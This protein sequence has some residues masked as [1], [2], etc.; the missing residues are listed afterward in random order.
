MEIKR[1]MEL[2]KAKYTRRWRG[3]D[4][5]W[6][7]EY[8]QPSAP[9][10]RA[11]N[12]VDV[13]SPSDMLSA[14]ENMRRAA[15]ILEGRNLPKVDSY[16]EVPVPPK[17]TAKTRSQ[18]NNALHRA[19]PGNYYDGV[20]IDELQDALKAEGYVLL[21]E[22]G[23]PWSG[24]FLGSGEALLEMGKLDYGRELNGLA[25]Y[26]PV[27]NS[28]LRMTWYQMPSGKMEIVKYIT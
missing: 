14:G 7:Y 5:K 1:P 9:K 2:L 6:H 20:P 28:G 16:S 27:P 23:T 12:K 24:M 15:G 3:P 8:K 22:D 21:Q 13:V 10:K 4:G 19:L 17:T 18:L 25:T 26:K 11:P